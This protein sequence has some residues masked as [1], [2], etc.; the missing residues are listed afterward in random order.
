MSRFLKIAVVSGVESA[1]QIHVDR[2]DNLNARDEKG[3]TP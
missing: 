3:Q 2:G 1:V